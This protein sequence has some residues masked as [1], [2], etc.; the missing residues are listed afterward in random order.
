MQFKAGRSL[1]SKRTLKGG[2]PQGT[3]IGNYLFIL[4]TNDLGHAEEPKVPENMPAMQMSQRPRENT[5]IPEIL[6]FRPLTNSCCFSTPT[7]RG[8]FQAFEPRSP[9]TKEEEGAS[10][11]LVMVT[12]S[13]A[14]ISSKLK[15][16]PNPARNSLKK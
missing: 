13:L 8:Q 7:T 12:K 14:Q 10:P 2:A 5:P 11:G 3:L 9:D 16:M 1:S 4:A 15:Y 6:P